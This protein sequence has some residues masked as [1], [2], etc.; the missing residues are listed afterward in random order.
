MHLVALPEM[1]KYSL[2]QHIEEGRG[3][4]R[5]KPVH[6]I[7]ASFR[8]PAIESVFDNRL[9][10]SSL[11]L[12]VQITRGVRVAFV[13]KEAEIDVTFSRF[14]VAVYPTHPLWDLPSHSHHDQTLVPPI[15]SRRFISTRLT[16]MIRFSSFKDSVSLLNS[17]NTGVVLR[18]MRYTYQLFGP[19]DATL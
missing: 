8:E 18:I 12:P 2:V 7:K 5:Y 9:H 6:R 17:L 10:G 15:F 4:R 14:L 16:R 11:E 3:G 1:I 13:S 19:Q